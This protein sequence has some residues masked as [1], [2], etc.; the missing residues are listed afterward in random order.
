MNTCSNQD[1]KS[2]DEIQFA[3]M[4]FTDTLKNYVLY[5]K[6]ND[7]L[8]RVYICCD[9]CYSIRPKWKEYVFYNARDRCS[10]NYD[11]H[12]TGSDDY[13]LC[14]KC[15]SDLDDDHKSYYEQHVYEKLPN[16]IYLS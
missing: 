11:P 9:R 13:K 7:I 12:Q 15:F 16:G 3:N 1:E 4:F 8:G 10:N 5:K 2:I 6:N 14:D